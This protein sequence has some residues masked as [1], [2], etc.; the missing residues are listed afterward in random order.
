MFE[1]VYAQKFQDLGLK[2]ERRGKLPPKM[3]H[4][5]ARLDG[6]RTERVLA[7]LESAGEVHRTLLAKQ[8]GISR[9]SVRDYVRPLIRDGLIVK[10][11]P[12][13]GSYALATNEEPSK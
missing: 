12:R 7:E 1:E 2:E 3:T 4:G 13:N 6:T 9:S 8:L 11:G 5:V 10:C